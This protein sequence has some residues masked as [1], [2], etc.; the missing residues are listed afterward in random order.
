L[1]YFASSC[2]ILPF[3]QLLWHEAMMTASPIYEYCFIEPQSTL[4]GWLDAK[5]S[6]EAYKGDEAA[7]PH[8]KATVIDH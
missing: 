7:P 5:F 1:R 6:S 2:V 3:Q 8:S 4:I